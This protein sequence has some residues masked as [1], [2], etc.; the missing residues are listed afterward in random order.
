[1]R[2]AG[3]MSGTSFD[4]ID[5]AVADFE[6]DGDD[7]HAAG[8]SAR[9]ARRTTTTCARRSRGAQTRL[10]R[11]PP[12]HADRPGVRG[13]RGAGA[14]ASYGPLDLIASHGQTLYHWV[15]DGT[16]H[17]HAAGRPARLDRR[18]H[19]RPGGRRPARRAT[20]P[21]AARAR[22]WSRCSTRCCCAP[23]QAALEPR[24]DREPDD[25]RGRVRRRPGE[26]AARRGGAG[27]DRPP[28]RRGRRAR[29]GRHRHPRS[30]SSGCSPT[31]TTR[32]PPRSRPGKEHFNLALP[33]RP[34][35]R[36]HPPTCSPP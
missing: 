18:A 32:A 35:R 16:V 20:S 34:Q 25:R 30:C 27:A 17:G 1:M 7:G 10:R 14:R 31:P 33:R 22:R 9:S 29:R 3:L 23:G 21:P 8:R 24:R 36:T 5:A 28:V 26:R 6:L 11:L 13:A 15:E 4:A 2:V 12:R 19:R